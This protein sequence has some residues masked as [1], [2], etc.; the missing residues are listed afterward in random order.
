MRLYL[1]SVTGTAITLNIIIKLVLA[2]T[3]MTLV[4]GKISTQTQ[5]ESE[6]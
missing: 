3:G 4:R 6:H 2:L 1:K 5:T